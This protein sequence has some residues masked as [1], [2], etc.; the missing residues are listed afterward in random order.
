MGQE[1]YTKKRNDILNSYA[2]AEFLNAKEIEFIANTSSLLNTCIDKN[3]IQI[4]VDR[5]DGEVMSFKYMLFKFLKKIENLLLIGQW[6]R[7]ARI[8]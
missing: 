7:W 2:N 5:F 4:T 1:I 8:I 6:P 3:A